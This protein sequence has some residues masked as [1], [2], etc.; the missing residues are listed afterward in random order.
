MAFNLTDVSNKVGV[1]LEQQDWFETMMVSNE[2]VVALS[3][4]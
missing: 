4:Q 2:I 3:Y 1:W